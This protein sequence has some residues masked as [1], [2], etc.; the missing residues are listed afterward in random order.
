MA[1]LCTLGSAL[2]VR[3]VALSRSTGVNGTRSS[4]T[5]RADTTLVRGVS[6][7]I[8]QSRASGDPSRACACLGALP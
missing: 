7:F 6:A 1:C 8:V 3:R 4:L 2:R 5:P